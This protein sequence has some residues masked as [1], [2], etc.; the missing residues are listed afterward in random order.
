MKTEI[1]LLKKVLK[2]NYS[3]KNNYEL[4]PETRDK[5]ENY[6]RQFKR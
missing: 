5:I 1:K 6:L 4:R 3:F 2:E